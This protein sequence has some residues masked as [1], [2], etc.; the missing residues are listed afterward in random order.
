MLDLIKWSL[1]FTPKL[2]LKIYSRPKSI[3]MWAPIMIWSLGWKGLI[4][5]SRF[6][7]LRLWAG[8][9]WGKSMCIWKLLTR[10]TPPNPPSSIKNKTKTNP[11]TSF[12][13]KSHPAKSV[14][15][16]ISKPKTIANN[17]T[18]LS[19]LAS[20]TTHFSKIKPNFIS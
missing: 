8:L 19:T 3:K 12:Y 14:N 9:K 16:S 4:R 20:H 6:M 2:T 1:T 17:S 13:S 7:I 10:N 15:P 18:E 11:E 5:G